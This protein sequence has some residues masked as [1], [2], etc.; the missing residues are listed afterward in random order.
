MDWRGAGGPLPRVY[1]AMS[2]RCAVI[3][4]PQAARMV[5]GHDG[6]AGGFSNIQE[7]VLP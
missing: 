7:R 2:M 5:Q 6:T 4:A 3:A 1:E